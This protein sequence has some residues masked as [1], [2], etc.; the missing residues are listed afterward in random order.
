[1]PPAS[2]Q[3]VRAALGNGGGV[4]V[5]GPA[6]APLSR[7]RG[8]YRAQ[9]LLKGTQRTPDA[10]GLKQAVAADPAL[11]AAS[12]IDVDPVSML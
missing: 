9:F 4:H 10:R 11:R 6:P 12:R 3:R 1:M 5:L 7:L 2:R 8:E